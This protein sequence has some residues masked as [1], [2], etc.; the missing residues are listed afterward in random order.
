MK[1]VCYLTF[2]QTML[3]CPVRVFFVCLPRT[4]TLQF[5]QVVVVGDGSQKPII[6]R[7]DKLHSM[8]PLME[9]G[10]QIAMPKT[11]KETRT[12]LGDKMF[13]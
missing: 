9:M 7:K 10:R 5:F 11:I 1:N 13:E 2:Q 6:I 12:E 4:K 3:Q 8:D